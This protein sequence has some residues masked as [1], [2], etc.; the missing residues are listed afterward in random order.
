[1]K[2]YLKCLKQY[3]NFDGRARRKEYW[4]FFL[5]NFIFALVAVALDNLFGT[6][7]PEVGIGVIYGLYVLLVLVP[8]IAVTVRR[9]HD[10][11]KSGWMILVALIP[12]AGPIWLL[13]L[14]V[15]DSEQGQ[16]QYGDNPKRA[17]VIA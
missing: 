5:F 6:S 2:W 3:A 9:L 16:N 14:T 13:V 12:L 17:E 8:G 4:M 15:T 11:G 10:I 7:N 1:M